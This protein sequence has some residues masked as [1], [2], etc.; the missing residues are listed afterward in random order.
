[1]ACGKPIASNLGGGERERRAA[2]LAEEGRTFVCGVVARPTIPPVSIATPASAGIHTQG[3]VYPGAKNVAIAPRQ[4]P[5]SE[6]CWDFTV[7]KAAASGQMNMAPKISPPTIKAVTPTTGRRPAAPT[8]VRTTAMARAPEDVG[9]TVRVV[10]STASSWKVLES[11]MPP[12][13]IL[14]APSKGSARSHGETQRPACLIAGAGVRLLR[15]C[16][17]A[18]AVLYPLFEGNHAFTTAQRRQGR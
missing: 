10:R 2:G 4:F 3:S 13:E 17:R 6:A 16:V 5:Y 11:R 9:S 14:Y 18:D 12:P 1:M 15:Y 7:S 8:I